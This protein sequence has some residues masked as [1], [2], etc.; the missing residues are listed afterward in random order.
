VF[1]TLYSVLCNQQIVG[2]R[3]AL[4]LNNREKNPEAG[5]RSA[6]A[7][8]AVNMHRR[9]SSAGVNAIPVKAALIVAPRAIRK[10]A[11]YSA[12][13]FSCGHQLTAFNVTQEATVTATPSELD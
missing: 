9:R 10:V 2:L 3:F 1:T 13:L 6:E 11:K 5:A 8:T 7:R 4:S 12:R